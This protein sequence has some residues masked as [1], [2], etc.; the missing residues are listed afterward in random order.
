MRRCGVCYA[1]VCRGVSLRSLYF[2]DNG[3][4]RLTR[5]HTRC[6]SPG[7]ARRSAPASAKHNSMEALRDLGR[8]HAALKK[9]IHTTKFVLPPWG[10]KVAKVV[11]FVVPVVGGSYVMKLAIDRADT[12]LAQVSCRTQTP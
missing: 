10:V 2:P 5:D 4:T 9:K 8:R 6:P 12:N 1:H 3:L 7:T 11:Y